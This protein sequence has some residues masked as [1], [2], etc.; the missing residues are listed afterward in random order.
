MFFL[1]SGEREMSWVLGVTFVGGN[2]TSFLNP[3]KTRPDL[4]YPSYMYHSSEDRFMIQSHNQSKRTAVP[5]NKTIFYEAQNRVV[6]NQKSK[7]G[8]NERPIL[9]IISFS[10]VGNRR[11][12]AS[13]VKN[14]SDN[15]LRI[16]TIMIATVLKEG[17]TRLEPLR[18]TCR[19]LT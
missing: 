3:F 12:K 16:R 10:P 17:K 14:H 9:R 11:F 19:Y 7:S 18:V 13:R 2:R 4:S 15:F 5:W 8:D 6:S 1:T